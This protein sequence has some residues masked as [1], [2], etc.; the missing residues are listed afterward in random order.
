[1]STTNALVDALCAY[2]EDR[3]LEH[4]QDCPE[5]DTC[6]CPLVRALSKAL[7]AAVAARHTKEN[8][9]QAKAAGVGG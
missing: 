3:G 8:D 5:D 9:E 1:V 2:V 7:D 4:D 6:E